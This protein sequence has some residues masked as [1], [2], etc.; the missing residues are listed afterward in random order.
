MYL[1][2]ELQNSLSKNWENGKG[3]IVKATITFEHIKVPLWTNRK[4]E[5]KTWKKQVSTKLIQL[6]FTKR[7]TDKLYFS[8]TKKA[9]VT[10]DTGYLKRT[11]YANL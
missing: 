9:S 11:K 4:L 10:V 5:N 1:N 6:A 3:E 7:L 2:A 8:R